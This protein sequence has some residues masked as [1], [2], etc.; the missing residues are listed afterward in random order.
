MLLAA[1]VLTVTPG[2][3]PPPPP[4][5][6][7]TVIGILVYE[8]PHNGPT[9]PPLVLYVPAASESVVFIVAPFTTYVSLLLT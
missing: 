2:L 1:G 3:P 8:G 5:L 7:E 6:V 9:P 4:P